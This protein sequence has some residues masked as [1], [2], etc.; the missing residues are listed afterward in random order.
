M[1]TVGDQ[2][3]AGGSGP[4]AR[5]RRAGGIALRGDKGQRLS[6]GQ[7]AGQSIGQGTQCG[8]NPGQRLVKWCF[9]LIVCPQSEQPLFMYAEAR[10]Q[11]EEMTAE[12]PKEDALPTRG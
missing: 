3:I 6:A 10:K 8:A 11:G 9:L 12:R 7:W 5:S 1:V 2:R 4:A